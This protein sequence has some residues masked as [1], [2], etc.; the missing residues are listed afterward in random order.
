MS[1][2]VLDV[3]CGSRPKG[4]VNVDLFLKPIHRGGEKQTINV[5]KVKNF[6]LADAHY[7]PFRDNSFKIVYSSHLLEHC[8]H[9]FQVLKEFHRIS[10]ML[11]YIEIPYGNLCPNDCHH[12]LYSWT[13]NSFKHFLSELFP[14]IELHTTERTV[15]NLRV[16]KKIIRGK[17][18]A[19]PLNF[20][21]NFILFFLRKLQR[22]LLW[23][24]QIT[25][26]CYKTRKS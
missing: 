9:P 5:K 18:F 8:L 6:V 15:Q 25:A 10:Q 4:D 23:R 26:L 16:K 21:G 2:R 24:T 3:G 19:F 13:F 11:V 22:S 1:F 14:Y 20:S 12:H 7:L 17:K